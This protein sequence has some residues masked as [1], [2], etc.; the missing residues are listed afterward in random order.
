[1]ADFFSSIILNIVIILVAFAV[2][3]WASNLAINN[4]VKVSTIT[5]LGKTAVG[6]TLIA[7]STSL[8]ELTVA[9]IAAFSGGAA[10]SIGNVLGSN[11]ANISIIIGVASVLV[12]L[13]TRREAKKN[14][15]NIVGK[16]IV[17]SL[18]QA[19]LGS[20][21][22]GLFISSVIPVVLIFI[23]TAA[24]LVGLVLI[25]IFVGYMY[26]LS[27][28]R[29]PEEETEPITI[30]KQRNLKKYVVYTI[31][32]AIGVVLSAFFLVESAVTIAET[33]GLSQQVIG[34]TIIAI[35]TSLPELTLDLKAILRGHAG[36]AFG[37]IIGSCF[38]NITLILGIGLFVPALLGTPVE[39]TISVFQNLVLFS[40]V[41]NLLLWYFLSR[42][43]IGHKEGLVFLFIYVLFVVT[44]IGV[45]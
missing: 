29:L 34:A 32:G 30:E 35:G 42:G 11:I 16:N 24:W 40:I 3:D 22:F 36:L 27:K 26:Q 25:G 8:P 17:K 44:T 21:Y 7:F 33:A 14:N 19:D 45:M 38:V 15:D 4:A 39:L 13:K 37:D 20:L 41:T 1:M 2:L 43:H 28:V 10:L 12:Y 9:V 5:R 18:A 6:F 31:A 23:S